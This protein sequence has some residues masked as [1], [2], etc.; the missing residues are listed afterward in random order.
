MGQAGLLAVK[1][2][3]GSWGQSEQRAHE[4]A[5]DPVSY[6]EAEDRLE[7]GKIVPGGAL[8]KFWFCSWCS[9]EL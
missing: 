3:K 9:S 8:R 4:S 7:K 1:G 5:R 6:G 2:M